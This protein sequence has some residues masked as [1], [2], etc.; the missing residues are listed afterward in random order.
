MLK[1]FLQEVE[2]IGMKL[3]QHLLVAP[4]ALTFLIAPLSAQAA[5]LNIDSV[6]DYSATLDLEQAKQL[7]QQVTSV[8]QFNDVYPT[9]WAYQALVRL[10]KTYGCVAG[11]PNG[12][13]RGYI[14]IT[15]YEAA[16]LLASCLDRVTEMTEEVEQ[17]LKE[18]ES[19]L[20]FVAG[21]IM[22]LEDRVGSL[23]ASQFSTTTKLKGKT[24][25]TMGSTKAYGTN[26]GSKYYWNYDRKHQIVEIDGRESPLGSTQN[27]RSWQKTRE[28]WR[29][30][31][32]RDGSLKEKDGKRGT[33][34]IKGT[35][36]EK[37][38]KDIRSRKF[39]DHKS[40][41]KDATGGG[42]RAYNSQYG[43]FTFNYEQKL[44]LKTSFTGK[45][46]LYASFTAGNFC[47]NAFAGDGV[48]LTKLSTAPCTEDILGLGRLYYRFPLK[49]DELID[50]SLIFIVGPM[51]RNTESLGM[52]P[53]AY[54]R[55]G[56]RILDWTG[57][58]GVP[59]VY[60]KA[61]GAM[62]GVIYK[63]KTENK[64]DPAFSV[65][66]NYVAEDG[67]DG[68]PVLGGM[69]TNNS[70]G[71]FLVQAGWGGEE[72][73]VAFAYRYGQC[74]TGQ[75]R[76]TN[77]MMD[78]S[79]NN[80]C[81]R[82]VWNWTEEDLYQ[83]DY[84][85]ERSERNSHNFA[86]NGYW[87]PQETGWIPSVSVGYARSAITG[88]GFFKYSPVASQSWFVGLKWDDVFDVGNDLG[89]GF[90]MP[91]FATELAGGHTPNDANYLVELYASFQV[92]DNI[93]ITPS[94]FWMTRPL[95]HYTASLSG[96]Q[97]QNGASTFGI[98]GGLIQSVFRF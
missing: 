11:Y 53:S 4:A 23:E 61:T 40:W 76:G 58:A 47:D 82:D 52:W 57:L 14:P 1:R 49:N 97:D 92:T 83:G 39:R 41:K 7:L 95:G 62:F 67:G 87:V 78:D 3:L 48:S 33:E 30:V 96:D 15:R 54:N 85:A 89:V 73:G 31:H 88:S 43:A 71:N 17:L 94:V 98:F 72:Y 36:L 70:R 64:G 80:E 44:N 63:E 5:D 59:N 51:A 37:H 25:F 77:F 29:A 46:L 91:N 16:A 90:G 10:V 86:L 19:E 50:H 93:Q 26:D 22:L 35:K 24:T 66:M 65:S 34:I 8:N 28:A 42:T 68:D 20:N 79:F 13:F 55:G 9:D 56:A 38:Y 12:S 45:D 18:F 2:G 74:G 6:S 69:F 32:N 60:N 75:R 84:I 21:S 27:S 81:W